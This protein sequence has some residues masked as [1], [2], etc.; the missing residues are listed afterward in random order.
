M[1]SDAYV[2]VNS[3]LYIAIDEGCEIELGAFTD[4]HNLRK[5]FTLALPDNEREAL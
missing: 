2:N 1:Y 4:D 5:T 3:L